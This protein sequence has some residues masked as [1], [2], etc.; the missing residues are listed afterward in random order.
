MNRRDFFTTASLLTATTYMSAC[1]SSN[2]THAEATQEAPTGAVT[3]YYGKQS[4][5]YYRNQRCPKISIY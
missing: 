5:T 3:L 1:A 2:S 4:F